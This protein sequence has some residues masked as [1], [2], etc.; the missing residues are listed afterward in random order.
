MELEEDDKVLPCAPRQHLR[1]VN[2]T[3]LHGRTVPA[4][5]FACRCAGTCSYSRGGGCII[6]LSEPLLKVQ[7]VLLPP[8]H[9][10][11]HNAC[12]TW[13]P[14]WMHPH[15]LRLLADAAGML[16]QF[17]PSSDLKETLLHEMVWHMPPAPR[18]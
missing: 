12:T 14:T 2:A 4:R 15:V 3:L 13:L 10:H 16:L 1:C 11:H 5:V 18:T 8:A 17:R 6:K 9:S 7:P